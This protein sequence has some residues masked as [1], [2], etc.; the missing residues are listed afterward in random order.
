M[1]ATNADKLLH[2][3][4][5]RAAR[6]SRAAIWTGRFLSAFGVLFL[7]F[8]AVTK[9]LEVPQVIEATNRIGFPLAAVPAIAVLEL[10]LLTFYL[11][12]RTAVIGA[13]LWTGYLG[14]AVAIH[15]RAGSPLFET[16]FPIYTAAF[17]W[18]GLWLRDRRVSSMWAR[19]LT[20]EP[21][22]QP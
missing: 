10:A 11:L 12:P 17:L 21:G 16:L 3:V 22:Y 15:V 13:I 14:G 20:G 18:A 8:D 19:V 6:S 5:P 4:E 2:A 7:A 9:L 1:S